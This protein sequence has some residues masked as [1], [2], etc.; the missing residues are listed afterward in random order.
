MVTREDEAEGVL[1]W[2]ALVV[3]GS[4]DPE[5]AWDELGERSV[6][7]W[8]R[9]VEAAGQKTLRGFVEEMLRES[10]WERSYGPRG[11]NYFPVRRAA[12]R[13]LARRSG[14]SLVVATAD[15][16]P[17]ASYS[18]EVD[19]FTTLEQNGW[20]IT[21][22]DE[23]VDLDLPSPV[24]PFDWPRVIRF[25]SQAR[26]S[27]QARAEQADLGWREVIREGL[28]LGQEAKRVASLTGLTPQRIYQIRDGR[29]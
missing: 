13:F 24:L 18:L 14:S 20:L 8:G 15:G 4:V 2:K 25:V 27:A 7:S 10:G 1:R 17:V 5:A 9:R 28:L 12:P 21:N 6:L 16:V 26:Q 19:E 22:A 29:R 11:A 3:P 23:D